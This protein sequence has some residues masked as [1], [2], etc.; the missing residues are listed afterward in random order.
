MSALPN[1][2]HESPKKPAGRSARS[3]KLNV[4]GRDPRSPAEQMRGQSDYDKQTG[5]APFYHAFWADLCRLSS[6]QSC[7]AL[8]GLLWDKSAGR[9]MRKG[10]ARPEWTPS[11]RVEDLAQICC[12][13]VRT[14]ERELAALDKRG[15]AE[16]RRSGKGEV[17]ARL[18]YRD[19]EALPNYKSA[20]VEMPVND[21][22]A[23]ELTGEDEAK[24]GNQRVTGKKPVRLPAGAISKAFPVSCGVK[25]FR[26][27]AEGPVDID[28]TCVIQAGELL[29]VSRF[30]EDWR[31]KVEKSIGQSNGINE[32]TSFPRYGCREEQANVGRKSAPVTHPRA[33]ELVKLFDPIL[34]ASAS[35]LLSGDSA[36]LLAACEAVAD[37]DHNFLVKFAVQRSERPVKSPLH[38]K[39][40]CAEALQSW[41]ASKVLDAAGLKAPTRAE[42]EAMCKRDAEAL[43]QA[44][45]E[46]NR[47]YKKA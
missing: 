13:D 43:K 2:L 1:P 38:V 45:S 32:N 14:V 41:K 40:I 35:R 29:V 8:V 4:Y 46:V 23:P 18:K 17:E 37:C 16:V 34:A 26:H 10:E 33:A 19:W 20:V 28:F 12:C 44:Q 25:T 9:G 11:L 21:E 30:P 36:S 27:K 47:R 6:G 3:G 7:M 39:T 15:I 22:T 42:I 24:P 31:Q 5:Y